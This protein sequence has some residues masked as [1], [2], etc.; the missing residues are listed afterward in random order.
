LF[1]NN[2]TVGFLNSTN[3][4]LGSKAATLCKIWIADKDQ[5]GFNMSLP[6]FTYL[7]NEDDDFIRGALTVL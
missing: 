6:Y 7:A 4:I 1:L 2:T 3:I 5:L